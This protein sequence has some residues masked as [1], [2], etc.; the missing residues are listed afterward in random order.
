MAVEV[1]LPRVDM[2]MTTGKITK[3]F[4]NEGDAV[5]KGQALFEIESDKAAMEVESPAAGVLR[6]VTGRPGD[7]LPVATVVGWI[8]APGEA[9]EQKSPAPAPAASAAAPAAPAGA[10]EDRP[11]VEIREA[12]PAT[13]EAMGDLRATPKARRLGRELGV[14]LSEVEGRGPAGRVQA[15][16]VEAAAAK[17]GAPAAHAPAGALANAQA[18]PAARRLAAELGVE[19]AG[20]KGTGE[21]GLVTKD[22]VKTAFRGGGF[23]AAPATA[24]PDVPTVDFEKFG[25]VETTPLSRIKRI[26]GPRLHAS[27]LNIPHV[28]HCDEADIT[29]LE[30]FRRSLDE[31]GKADK[32]AYRVS[33]L[34]LVIKCSVAALKAFPL[35]N[36][37]LLP[38]K[39]GLVQR[40][41]W[42]I[43]VA[44]DTPDGLVVAVVREA[45]RKGVTEIARELG[46]LSAKAREGKLTPAE[47][48]GATFTISSLG[49]IGGTAFTPIVNAPE[50]A[51]L[52]VV[53]A[54][55]APVWD[56]TAFQPRLML[57]LCLSYDHRVIDGAAAARFTRRL[58]DL[59]TD[60]RRALL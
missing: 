51:I 58:A 48:Q 36:S 23:A 12:S 13:A 45:D 47:M 41:Y 50:V 31:A 15:A 18:G 37:A 57:P 32:D 11:D 42:N 8:V 5:T 52:G 17:R 34:P 26:S 60:I 10:P 24:I 16:D 43:G 19:I 53:R 28:T 3:W 38:G 25:P 44:I 54:S 56:G 55:M 6:G 39:D 29:E 40:N 27:W 49:G 20:V 7:E 35:F 1:I 4:A 21:K 22:D 46:A 30:A 14:A 59:L 2:D 9:F 33:L